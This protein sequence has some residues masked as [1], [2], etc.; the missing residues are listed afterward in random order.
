MIPAGS[1][2]QNL[3]EQIIAIS[4]E[5]DDK[6]NICKKLSKKLVVERQRL[7]SI[8]SRINAEYASIIEVNSNC[9]DTK[10]SDRSSILFIA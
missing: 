4:V 7:A 8:E 2:Y 10:R 6:D 9:I 1:F 5:I 3:R